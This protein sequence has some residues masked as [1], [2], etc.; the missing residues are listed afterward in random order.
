[1]RVRAS[2]FFTDRYTLGHSTITH[3]KL[4]A[5]GIIVVTALRRAVAAAGWPGFGNQGRETIA[6]VEDVRKTPR[7]SFLGCS[8]N[9]D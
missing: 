7:H 3:L 2:R 1:M 8:E 5:F 9:T 4:V 6:R